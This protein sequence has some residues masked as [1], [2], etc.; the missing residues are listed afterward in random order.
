MILSMLL[1]SGVQ[2]PD[3]APALDA[4]KTCNRV[5]I[6]KMISSEPHRRTEFAAAAYAEQ[7][8]IARERAILLAPPMANPAAGTPAGQASTAN[9]LTQIDARQKQ[10]DDARAI[11]TSWRE[12]FDEMRADFLANCNGKKDTQ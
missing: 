2:I 10:L 9:A 5:E 7:R 3:S 4:V 11:E 12:L 6:R 1:L 8:D